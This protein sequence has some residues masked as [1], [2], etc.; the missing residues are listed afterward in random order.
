M[1]FIITIIV[2]VGLFVSA[3]AE[4]KE[5][6][7]SE[8]YA[9]ERKATEIIIEAKMVRTPAGNLTVELSDTKGFK[10]MDELF[11]DT[12]KVETIAAPPKLIT[13]SGHEAKMEFSYDIYYIE[14]ATLDD[15]GDITC[16]IKKSKCGIFFKALPIIS[17][18][19]PNLITVEYQFEL[20]TLV[21][22]ATPPIP[23]I[24]GI[25]EFESLWCPI[26]DTTS[27][28]SIITVKDGETII[29]GGISKT[30]GIVTPEGTKEIMKHEDILELTFLTV[31]KGKTGVVTGPPKKVIAITSEELKNK[32]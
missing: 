29:S 1:R 20:N 16:K 17:E 15:N 2:L 3:F 7:N 4:E 12:S 18:E 24:A 8:I 22:R 21:K 27:M 30:Q 11:K 10:N 9:S 5:S 23:A 19:D 25:R 32:E 14:N 6:L 13:F 31:K 28:R 26:M